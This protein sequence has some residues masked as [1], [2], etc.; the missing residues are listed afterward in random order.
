MTIRRMTPALLPLAVGGHAVGECFPAHDVVLLSNVSLE[1]FST[2]PIS[3]NDCWGY[4][5]PSGREYALMG[6]DLIHRRVPR[7]RLFL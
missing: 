5:S 7:T 4:T 3:G 6:I 2:N 1:D